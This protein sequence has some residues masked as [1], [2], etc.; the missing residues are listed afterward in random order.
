V[1]LDRADAT[2]GH[3]GGPH[4]AGV[5]GDP[6]GGQDAL[7]HGV[8]SGHDGNRVGAYAANGGDGEWGHSGQTDGGDGEVERAITTDRMLDDGD[9]PGYRRSQNVTAKERNF[10]L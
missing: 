4:H 9:G 1:E 6:A 7:G 5:I 3:D 2:N 10:L 8:G